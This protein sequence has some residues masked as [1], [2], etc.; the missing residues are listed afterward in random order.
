MDE[1]IEELTKGD[2]WDELA[3]YMQT[4][5]AD[6]VTQAFVA[7]EQGRNDDPRRGGGA[8]PRG[9]T[10]IWPSARPSAAGST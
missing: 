9:S 2:E 3:R 6:E 8:A 7:L 10:S 5:V 1:R 4:V